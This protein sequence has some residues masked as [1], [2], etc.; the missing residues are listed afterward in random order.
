[1]Y[2]DTKLKDYGQRIEILLPT[3]S[4][5]IYTEYLVNTEYLKSL[6]KVKSKSGSALKTFAEKAKLSKVD[7]E[8]LGLIW[9]IVG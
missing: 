3:I 8:Y 5:N 7:R 1:M 4:E 6:I 2:T 9:Y